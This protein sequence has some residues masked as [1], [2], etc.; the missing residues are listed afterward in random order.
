MKSVFWLI[1]GVAAGFVLAHRVDKT[2]QGKQFFGNLDAKAKEFGAAVADSYH[3]REAELRSAIGD[4]E[5]AVDDLGK[6]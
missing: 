3:K 6:N 5:D 2:Q 1:V 4:T